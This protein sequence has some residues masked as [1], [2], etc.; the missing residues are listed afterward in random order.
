[1][2]QDTVYSNVHEKLNFSKVS[3][4]WVSKML[5]DD[6]K[7]QRLM[8]PRASLRRYRKEGDAF[9][10]RLVATD[11]TWIFHYNFQTS[12]SFPKW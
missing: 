5:T 1:M 7:M 6:H 10:S 11:E 4:R 12:G 9:L 8:A 3:C 2:S